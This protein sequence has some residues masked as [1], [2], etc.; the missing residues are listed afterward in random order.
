MCQILCNALRIYWWVKAED[1][2]ALRVLYSCHV[3]RGGERR[4]SGMA[5]NFEGQE[6]WP[7]CLQS[8]PSRPEQRCIWRYW[9]L[10]KEDSTETAC[11]LH[12][13][14]QVG[15]FFYPGTTDD[16]GPW[17]VFQWSVTFK[18]TPTDS[19]PRSTL[20]QAFL[21]LLGISRYCLKF[22]LPQKLT[23]S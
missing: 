18:A 12:P 19:I 5:D 20:P 15:G 7:R 3:R 17:P 8:A 22:A 13:H 21:Y 14:V 9:S 10:S 2:L 4:E 1:F 11:M 6:N 16:F 23:I